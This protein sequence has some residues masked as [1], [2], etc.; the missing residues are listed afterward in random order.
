MSIRSQWSRIS[1]ILCV[2]V[3]LFTGGTV[4]FAAE[5]VSFAG[6][7]GSLTMLKVLPETEW[8][9]AAPVTHGEFVSLGEKLI[10]GRGETPIYSG[11]L[12]NSLA[13]AGEETTYE[14]ALTFA[15]Q[16]M[17]YPV[18]GGAER[19]KE[20]TPGL[21]KADDEVITGSEMAYLFYHLLLVPRAGESR[22]LLEE[23]Y[24]VGGSPLTASKLLQVTGNRVILEDEGEIL[25]ADDLQTFALV[26]GKYIPSRFSSIP[27]GMSDLQFLF[28]NEGRLQT[29][30]IPKRV[31]PSQ[32]R[33]LIS[34]DISSIGGSNSYDF[35]DVKVSADKVFKIFTSQKGFEAVQYVA[36]AK[37]TVSLTNINGK[38]KLTAGKYSVML[39]SNRVYVK[40]FYPFDT[41]IKIMSTKRTGK[42]PAYE[43]HLEV[44][45]AEQGG[46]LYVINELP[47]EMYL[48][49]VVPSEIPV[50]WGKEA[51]K[52]QAVSAR[53]YAI[54]QI[55]ANRFANRSANVDDSTACQ[56][57]NNGAEHPVVN[58]A[59]LETAGLIPMYKG[60][61][62]D[63]VFASTTAGYT[64]NSHE[65]WNDAATNE[66]PGTPV[67]Y[68]KARTQIIDG[69]PLEMRDEAVALAFYKDWS[70][71]SYDAISPF[72]RW[73]LELTRE[74]LENTINANLPGREQA[75]VTLAADFIR[76]VEGALL[77]AGDTAFSIGTLQ[78]LKVVQRGEGGNIMTL[79]VVGSNGTYRIMKEYNIRFVIRPV[80]T[81]TRTKGDVIIV[82]YDN[83]NLRNYSILPSAFFSFEIVRNEQGEIG[84]VLFYGGGNGHGVGMSQWG[85]KGMA[86]AGIPFDVIL[87]HY[88]DGIELV[89]IY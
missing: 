35:A 27:V 85:M 46:H 34:S 15:A 7:V 6:Q 36:E 3:V 87:K 33:V 44:I 63:A 67:P 8:R 21:K 83:S 72:Y 4:S 14:Q 59:I 68:L 37:E 49:K 38:I 77:T 71:K 23:R 82:R 84:K 43:G 24:I 86:D 79:D 20:L 60:A 55:A 80:N 25:M 29:V 70:L 62:V 30:V 18:E 31:H 28:N 12:V 51:F 32:I 9:A 76:T 48:K 73:K 56:M 5:K 13:N 26:N 74:E 64:A 69:K 57:Y 16:L 54:S 42:N 40:S 50:S 19:V 53:S 1:V 75:D 81:M 47:I 89:R 65:V 58:E 22:T 78:D 66:F 11:E 88:Y 41:P 2:L 61:V 10:N 39:D 52:V 17:G 45:S